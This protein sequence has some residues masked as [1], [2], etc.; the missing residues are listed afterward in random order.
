[1]KVES[2]TGAEPGARTSDRPNQRIRHRYRVRCIRSG[3]SNCA[4]RNCEREAVPR[5]WNPAGRPP[6]AVFQ[7]AS[8]SRRWPDP[9][10]G[11]ERG[12][13]SVLRSHATMVR[14]V[15]AFRLLRHVK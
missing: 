14:L 8:A 5:F 10:R 1:M 2:L 11:H 3:R 12:V 7:E 13:V 6:A 9:G 15:A 4:V